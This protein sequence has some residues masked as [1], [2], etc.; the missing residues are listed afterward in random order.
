MK[1]KLIITEAQFIRLERILTEST[2][3]ADWVKTMSEELEN[4]YMITDKFIKE[5]GDYSSTPMF[6]VKVD[7]EVITPKDLFEYMKHKYQDEVG[8][9]FVQQVIRDWVDKTI[10]DDYMLSKNVPLK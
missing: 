3:H 8:D 9:K 5:G 7:E 4:N 6:M 2:K 10:T 1:K